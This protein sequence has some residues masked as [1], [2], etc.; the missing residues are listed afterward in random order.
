MLFN[1][2]DWFIVILI[3]IFNFGVWKYKFLKKLTSSIYFLFFFLFFFLIPILTIGVEIKIVVSKS[4]LVEAFN[5]IYTYL[6]FP[7]WWFIGIIELF[8]IRY[9]IENPSKI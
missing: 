3:L 6:R 7:T 4:P 8:V 5:L 2:F 9:L 1:Y